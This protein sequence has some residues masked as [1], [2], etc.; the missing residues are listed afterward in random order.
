[1]TAAD[2]SSAGI[3]WR[4]KLGDHIGFL[5]EPVAAHAEG[6]RQVL[7]FSQVERPGARARTVRPKGTSV[8]LRLLFAG[9]SS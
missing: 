2:G 4:R 5:L 3:L 9:K 1:M 7:L 8:R 6:S